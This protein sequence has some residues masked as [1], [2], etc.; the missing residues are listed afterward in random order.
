MSEGGWIER[1]VMCLEEGVSRGGV[2]VE[3]RDGEAVS[4]DRKRRRG[5][6]RE[7]GSLQRMR[8]G[9]RMAVGGERFNDGEE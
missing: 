6:R 4:R 5:E 7:K 3:W 1:G 9:R 8:G 2:R